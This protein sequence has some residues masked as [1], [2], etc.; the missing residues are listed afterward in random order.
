MMILILKGI[1]FSE[2][3]KKPATRGE[4]TGN[5]VDSELLLESHQ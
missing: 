4:M 1:Y 2:G 3:T 5:V